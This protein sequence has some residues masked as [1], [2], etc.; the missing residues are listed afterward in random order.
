MFL[1]QYPFF[2]FL[3]S[4][5]DLN[6]QAATPSFQF[7]NLCLYF[8]CIFVLRRERSCLFD[9]CT[10]KALILF[11]LTGIDMNTEFSISIC[12]LKNQLICKT[13]RILFKHQNIS[14]LYNLIYLFNENF[15][16]KNISKLEKNS[17]YLA[18]KSYIFPLKAV[19]SA[20]SVPQISNL[21]RKEGRAVNKVFQQI[22]ALPLFSI[23]APLDDGF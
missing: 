8:S 1:Q 7:T 17:L 19:A 6:I 22:G 4:K 5:L 14:I 9:P 13:T 12:E 20:L 23:G 21:R 18:L 11:M 10:E 3:Q 2:Q 16:N 15:T